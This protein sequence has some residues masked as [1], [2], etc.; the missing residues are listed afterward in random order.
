MYCF[1]VVTLCQSQMMKQI[2][3]LITNETETK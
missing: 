3:T 2:K 1:I